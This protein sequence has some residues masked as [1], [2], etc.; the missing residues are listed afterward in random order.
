MLNRNAEKDGRQCNLIDPSGIVYEAVEGNVVEGATATLYKLNEESGEW[1]EWNAVDFEQQN[2]ILT[3]S[4]GAYAWLTNEGRFKV[5]ISKEGYETQ[6][7]E[8]FDVPPEKLGLNFSLVDNTTHPTAA[9]ATGEAPGTFTLTFN[10]YMRPETV[11]ADTIQT[12]GLDHVS[13]TPV[14]LNEGDEYADTYTV[15]GTPKKAEITFTVT[16]AAQSYSGVSAETVTETVT[17]TDSLSIGDVNLDGRITISDVTAIQRHIAEIE[18]LSELQLSLADTNGDGEIN[19]NDGTHLQKYLAE[20]DGI[21]L[22]KQ[23]T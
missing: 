6:T 23:S 19:I 16:D 9:I 8:E 7:S 3:N 5:T 20:L 17:V 22:G 13:I 15:T 1:V 14:Y 4:E 12:D 21:V 18:Q 11:T 10:K 2:P